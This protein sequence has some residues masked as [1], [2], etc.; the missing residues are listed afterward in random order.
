MKSFL[1]YFRTDL[2]WAE[3]DIEAATPEQALKQALRIATDHPRSLDYNA[4]DGLR[5]INAI[6]VCDDEANLLLV[7]HDDDMR[8]RLAARDLLQAAELVIARWEQ[9][10]LAEAVRAL[11]AAVVDAKGGAP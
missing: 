10:D 6:E 5:S 2:Q 8:L 1:I 7:W 9:G 4:Y 11:E 3:L